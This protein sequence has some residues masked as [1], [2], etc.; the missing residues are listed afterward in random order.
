MMRLFSRDIRLFFVTTALV[1][2]AWDGVRMVLFNLYLLRLGYGPEFLGLVSGLGALTFSV[3]CLPA[4]A[5]GTRWS[6]RSMMILGLSLMVAGFFL[7]P[8]VEFVPPSLRTA[9]LVGA[10]LLTYPGFALYLVN[11][12]PFTMA[13]TGIEER[14]HVFSFHQALSPL[15]AFVGSVLGGVMPGLFAG[16]MGSTTR[17]PAV[18]RFPLLLA[19]LLMVPAIVAMVATRDKGTGP[20]EETNPLPGSPVRRSPL[21]LSLLMAIGV[22]MLLR[23]SGR[24]AVTTF[25]NVYMDDAL[26]ASAVLIGV[27]V[28]TGQLLSV[29]SALSAPMWVARWGSVAS[30]FAGTLLMAL[31]ALPLAVATHAA[32]AGLG[33]VSSAVFFSATIGPVRVFSQE[34]VAPRWRATM[35]AVF[36]MGAG[37]AFSSVSLVGGFVITAVGYQTLFLIG[38][39]LMA[40]ATL[41]FWVI[42]RVPRGEYAQRALEATD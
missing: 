32:G 25:F 12:L 15:A 41:V 42:F 34:L 10:T 38:A 30:I 5:M 2:F 31:S 16:L 9:W 21:P 20:L 1:A 19:A 4:G 39:G 26:G 33:Y 3:T 7:L 40:A 11:G 27:L 35:A 22:V 29:L 36:M 17:D 18:Y 37:L 23:Y 28:G 24:G 13:A 6:N 8:L 14:N